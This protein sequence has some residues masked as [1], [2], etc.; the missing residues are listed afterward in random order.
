MFK[1]GQPAFSLQRLVTFIAALWLL[2][3]M[4]IIFFLI[5]SP[6]M[7][8]PANRVDAPRTQAVDRA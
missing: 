8:K 4:L 1:P 5:A 2:V 7:S 6:R 3:T